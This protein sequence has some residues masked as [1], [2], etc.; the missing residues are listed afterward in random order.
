MDHKTNKSKLIMPGTDLEQLN[1]STWD[2]KGEVE[3]N[4]SN[5]EL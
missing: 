2:K 5:E 3:E 4:I 1:L